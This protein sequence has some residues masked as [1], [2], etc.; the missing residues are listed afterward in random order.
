[1]KASS[2][3]LSLLLSLLIALSLS[4][5]SNQDPLNSQPVCDQQLME[6]YELDGQPNIVKDLNLLCPSI[7]AN[8]C[9]Y[10]T[11]IN[12]FKKWVVAEEEIAITN[13][14]SDFAKI[15]D[16]IFQD[17]TDV[18]QITKEVEEI[19]QD[20]PN[21]NC[22]KMAKTIN[23]FKISLFRNIV[24]DVIAKAQ[25][26]LLLSRRGFYCSLCDADEHLFYNLG[27][28]KYTMSHTF[29]AKM[30]ESTLGYY[31]FKYKFFVK[32][33]RLY[34]EFLVKCDFKGVYHKNNFLKNDVKFYKKDEIV[35]DIE[36]CKKGFNKEG[37]ISNCEDF[38]SRFNPVKYDQYLE[39][40]LDKLHQ[41]HGYFRKQMKRLKD[42]HT[43]Q[44][45]N[46]AEDHSRVV[47]RILEESLTGITEESNEVTKFNKEFKTALVR[48]IPY[49]FLDDLSIRMNVNFE[50]PVIK[51]SSEVVFNL[52]DFEGI[53]APKGINFF[54]N[55]ESASIDKM[56]AERVFELLNPDL[57]KAGD[58]DQYLKKS[59]Y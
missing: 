46:E 41:L 17:L 4:N 11:Q 34:S 59:D 29:C 45:S 27:K 3:K 38:C 35:G 1:M 42:K 43:H 57:R 44:L 18:E 5:P 52:V 53:L 56:T 33:S 58:L 54:E 30:V 40:E 21:S 55:G 48:P 47:R 6:S 20:I 51:Q 14:Y 22:N 9:S 28:Q 39:G 19:T 10:A 2:L 50:E 7:E 37:S 36:T 26:F 31:L 12:I 49:H 15:F 32:I 24:K 13:F 23:K 25:N 8:C 16:E